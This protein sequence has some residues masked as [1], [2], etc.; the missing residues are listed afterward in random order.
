[1][2]A[3]NCLP[4]TGRSDATCC[5]GRPPAS[6]SAWPALTWRKLWFRSVLMLTTM[7]SML[8]GRLPAYCGFFSKTAWRFFVQLLMK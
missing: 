2:S 1:V 5:G 7:R 4:S 3:K 8:R 6:K